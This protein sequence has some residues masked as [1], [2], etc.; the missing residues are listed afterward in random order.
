MGLKG[1]V[2]NL[3]TDSE[4]LQCVQCDPFGAVDISH[5]IYNCYSKSLQGG[6]NLQALPY[7]F[8]VTPNADEICASSDMSS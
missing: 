8:L 1:A 6:I 2:T 4:F 5:L 7:L 3:Q